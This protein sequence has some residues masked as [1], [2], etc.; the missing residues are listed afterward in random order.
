MILEKWQRNVTYSIV[1]KAGR[2]LRE[3]KCFNG[4]PTGIDGANP[5]ISKRA[6]RTFGTSVGRAL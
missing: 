1:W 3:G 6:G 2:L 5:F 4:L